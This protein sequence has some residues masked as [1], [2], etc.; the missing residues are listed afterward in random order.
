[1]SGKPIGQTIDIYSRIFYVFNI[2]LFFSVTSIIIE[3]VGLLFLSLIKDDILSD[4]FFSLST[5]FSFSTFSLLLT[6]YIVDRSFYLTVIREVNLD[7]MF[8]K[9][10]RRQFRLNEFSFL[11]FRNRKFH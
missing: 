6:E 3:I 10:L 5:N 8:I 4:S 1:M 9:M 11:L 7:D 2:R